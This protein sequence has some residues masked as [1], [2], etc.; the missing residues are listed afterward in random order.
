[1]KSDTPKPAWLPTVT[2]AKLFE[3]QNQFFDALASYEIISHHDSS[4]EIRKKIEEL[5]HRILTDPNNRYDKRIENLFSPE[6]LTYLKILS[7]SAFENLSR[8]QIHLREPEMDDEPI[9]E[10]SEEQ[11]PLSSSEQQYQQLLEEIEGLKKE[12]ASQN[13]EQEETPS[14][15]DILKEILKVFGKNTPVTG[16]IQMEMAKL[17]LGIDLKKNK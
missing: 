4:P 6:E 1:M 12:Y 9:L 3:E 17:I 5:Q 15:G 13:P 8:T 7:H 11:E 10:L 16:D 14:V 2:L